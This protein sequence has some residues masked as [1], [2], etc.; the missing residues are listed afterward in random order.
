M[1]KTKVTVFVSYARANKDLA[2]RFLKHFKQQT[3]ASKTYRYVFWQ[4]GD[5]LVGE[6]WNQEI[7]KALE[8]CK[9]GLLLVSPAFLGSKYI[10]KKEL[11]HFVGRR[12]T[13]VIPVMLQPIDRKLHDLKGLQYTQIFRLE[14]KSFQSPKA[15]AD[16]VGTRRDE[17]ALELFRRVDARLGQLFPGQRGPS[18]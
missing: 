13:P 2:P 7:Q 1:G 15:F 10:A 5:I 18:R 6:N 3:D 11:P 4:D 12:A 17:F 9:L 14:R 8:S 16:C